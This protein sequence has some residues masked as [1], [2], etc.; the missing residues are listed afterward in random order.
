MQQRLEFNYIDILH[1]TSQALFIITAKGKK[2]WVPRSQINL[3]YDENTIWIPL[4]L[5]RKKGLTTC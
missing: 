5:A 3:S 1:K 4:W 2:G